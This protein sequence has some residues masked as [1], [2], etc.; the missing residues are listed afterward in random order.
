MVQVKDDIKDT[1]DDIR[2]MQRALLGTLVTGVGSLLLLI[3]EFALNH[4]LQHGPAI[5]SAVN[6]P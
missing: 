3:I 6:K 1:K 2:S 5:M 4:I